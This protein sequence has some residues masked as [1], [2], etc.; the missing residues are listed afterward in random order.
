MY[1]S[2]CSY[3]NLLNFPLLCLIINLSIV[4]EIEDRRRSDLCLIQRQLLDK[5]VT[6]RVLCTLIYS[7]IDYASNTFPQQN[8]REKRRGSQNSK[9][10]EKITC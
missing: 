3:R 7:N 2:T 1:F 6:V 10:R 9:R 8:E 4:N 5:N